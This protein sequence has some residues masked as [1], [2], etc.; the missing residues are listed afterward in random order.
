MLVSV[1]CQL[2]GGHETECQDPAALYDGMDVRHR[3]LPADGEGRQGKPASTHES[4]GS[5]FRPRPKQSYRLGT[6]GLSHV[7]Y[8]HFPSL[9]SPIYLRNYIVPTSTSPAKISQN[10]RGKI[11]KKYRY[12]SVGKM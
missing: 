7:S 4:R 1:V 11:R 8:T 3:L 12:V 9:L 5:D 10:I 6:C 2:D